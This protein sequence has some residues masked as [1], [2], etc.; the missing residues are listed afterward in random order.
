M[1][2]KK[3]VVFNFLGAI[4]WV[5]VIASAGFLFGRHWG[6]LLE[7]LDRINLIVLVAAALLALFVWLRYRMRQSR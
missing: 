6:R 5:T 2:W 7:I 3:F 4:L 1:P